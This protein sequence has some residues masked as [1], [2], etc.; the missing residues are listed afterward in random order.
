MIAILAQPDRSRQLRGVRAPALVIHGTHDKMVHV[1][2][3]RAT[4]QA[5]PGAELLLVP[6]MGHDLPAE[7]RSTFVDAIRRVADRAS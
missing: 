5:I 6:G 7:L 1:S 2:G 3:G 4:A